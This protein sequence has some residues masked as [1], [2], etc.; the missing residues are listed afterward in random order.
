MDQIRAKFQ[1]ISAD[2][3]EYGINVHCIPV[4]G[5]SEENKTFSK[6]TP[7]GEL[8][9][10]ITNPN[11]VDF[12]EKGFEYVAVITKVEIESKEGA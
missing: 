8:R 9:L 11:V 4:Y 1:L 3:N 5:D 6:Y 7:S 10:N 2:K 12:F